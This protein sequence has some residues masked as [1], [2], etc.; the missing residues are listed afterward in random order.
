MHPF[1][2]ER[3]FFAA[4]FKYPDSLAATFL[5]HARDC[6]GHHT[7]MAAA[8]VGLVPVLT[9]VVA[10]ART[11]MTLQNTVVATAMARNAF[12]YFLIAGSLR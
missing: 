10:S 7:S 4:A 11:A 6:A 8:H 2:V 9:I 3:G 1:A 5:A 12:P